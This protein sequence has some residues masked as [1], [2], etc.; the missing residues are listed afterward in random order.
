MFFE[1]ELCLSCFLHENDSLDPAKSNDVE[2]DEQPVSE[3]TGFVTVVDANVVQDS[4]DAGYLPEILVL[5]AFVLFEELRLFFFLAGLDS[6]TQ[7]DFLTDS[8]TNN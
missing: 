6:W 2:E 1:I 4:W 5:V 7:V 8:K 3:E